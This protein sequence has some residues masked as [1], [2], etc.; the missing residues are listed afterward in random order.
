M[1]HNYGDVKICLLEFAFL[2]ML[3]SAWF[4]YN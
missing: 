2:Y 1:G 3:G 4:F